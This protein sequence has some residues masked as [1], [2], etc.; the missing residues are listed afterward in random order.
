MAK[1]FEDEHRY[2]LHV[3]E[4]EAKIMLKIAKHFNYMILNGNVHLEAM[5]GLLSFKGFG[6]TF[7]YFY[8]SIDKYYDVPEHEFHC[9][10]LVDP[11]HEN[12]LQELNGRRGGP[13]YEVHSV[14]FE[15]VSEAAQQECEINDMKQ[16]LRAVHYRAGPLLSL[17]SLLDTFPTNRP[18]KEV[19][20][21]ML[22]EEE[23]KAQRIPEA[24]RNYMCEMGWKLIGQ[25]FPKDHPNTL[26]RARRIREELEELPRFTT[27][28]CDDL[29]DHGAWPR[30]YE[31]VRQQTRR[32]AEVLRELQDE[33]EKTPHPFKCWAVGPK[34][35][36]DDTDGDPEYCHDIEGS[37]PLKKRLLSVSFG[38]DVVISEPS[39]VSQLQK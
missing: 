34:P 10:Y 24:E 16:D 2:G 25:G 39:L 33:G 18:W 38:P 30:E 28:L 4:S 22:A 27:Y 1:C 13:V 7:R 11:I 12:Y 19:Y 26:E 31:E 5:R 29:D 15:A 35:S 9:N 14:W 37:R 6:R 32:E 20:Q 3:T 36:G 21:A 17:I 8:P 23:E